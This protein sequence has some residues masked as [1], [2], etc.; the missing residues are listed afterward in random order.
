MKHVEGPW[1]IDH[2]DN[3]DIYVSRLWTD[4]DGETHTDEICQVIVDYAD[5]IPEA[6]ARLIAACPSL[7]DKCRELIEESGAGR[8]LDSLIEE[9]RSVLAEIDKD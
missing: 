4:E 7:S 1:Q 9:I 8:S 6:N 5:G 2:I 3:G